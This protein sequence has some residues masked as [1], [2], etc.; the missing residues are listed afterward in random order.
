MILIKSFS[1]IMKQLIS[2]RLSPESFAGIYTAF[3]SP[4][5]MF[6]EK[7]IKPESGSSFS[8]PNKNFNP[9]SISS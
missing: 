1:G 4:G 7:A 2:G 5:V 3:T 9:D 6:L 8:L